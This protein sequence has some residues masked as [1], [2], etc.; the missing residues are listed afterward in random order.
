MRN[1]LAK[2]A[3]GSGRALFAVSSAAVAA[4]AF[5]YLFA[6]FRRGDPFAAQFAISGVDVPVHFFLAGLA[7]LLGPLQLSAG[8]RRRWPVLHRLSGWLYASAVLLAGASGLSLAMNAQGGAPA[9]AAF[10]VLA[11]LWP[12]VTAIGVQRA[13]VRDFE[14]HRRWMCRSVALTFAAVTLRVILGVGAGALQLPFIPVYIAAAWLGWTV[15]LAVC[16]AWLRW[17]AMRARRGRIAA[18]ARGV[19]A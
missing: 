6:D 17:P 15:N 10:V 3:R 13:V 16:E 4:Y 7:L 1:L 2:A 14:G 18:A 5:W 19:S 8:L 9:R 11:L 12:V